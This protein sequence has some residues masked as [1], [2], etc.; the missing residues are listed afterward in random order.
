MLKLPSGRRALWTTVV[1]A[2]AL[3][4]AAAFAMM[5]TSTG[6]GSLFSGAEQW[7]GLEVLTNGAWKQWLGLSSYEE[8]YARRYSKAQTTQTLDIAVVYARDEPGLFNGLDLA[9]NGPD[10]RVKSRPIK[11]GNRQLAVKLHRF[12]S[13]SGS[14]ST[15]V[16]VVFARQI[17]RDDRYVAVV[18]HSSSDIASLASVSYEYTK[19]LFMATTA[20]DPALTNHGFAYVF[21]NIVTDEQYAAAVAQLCRRLQVARVGTFYEQSPH[22]L[23]AIDDLQEALSSPC[24]EGARP[25]PDEDC[26]SIATLFEKSYEALVGTSVG[27]TLEQR[28]RKERLQDQIAS[29]E[30]L[31]KGDAPPQMIAIVGDNVKAAVEL[32]KGLSVSD[33]KDVP[34]VIVGGPL[35]T[36]AFT[37]NTR[38]RMSG[39]HTALPKLLDLKDKTLTIEKK[40]MYVASLFSTAEATAEITGTDEEK[41][42]KLQEGKDA[43]NKFIGDYGA[44][45]KDPQ[46]KP[47]SPDAISMRGFT[48]GEILRKA[49]EQSDSPAPVDVQETLKSSQRKFRSLGRD[50]S[51]DIRGDVTVDRL[52]ADSPILFKVFESATP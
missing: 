24:T 33:M 11:V 32:W 41:R 12:E 5:R 31:M 23:S 13:G 46:N 4:L 39:S 9:F 2:V 36:D 35:D 8:I 47:Q 18:G 45:F 21:R 51:F 10:P 44:R 52:G 38:R 27:T 34:V 25:G 28:E 26:R 17:A 50:F 20:T 48:A 40:A 7:I 3:L 1:V 43:V 15:G 37:D 29:V 19:L 14:D 6:A 49:F 16:Q 30:H 42:R 22:S